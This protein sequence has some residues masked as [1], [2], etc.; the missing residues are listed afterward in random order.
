MYVKLT[1]TPLRD[2]GQ[3]VVLVV[4]ATALVRSFITWMLSLL[5]T[6][7]RPLAY[8][9]TTVGW[10]LLSIS[11]LWFV[12]NQQPTLLA[13][14]LSVF[15]RLSWWGQFCSVK[16]QLVSGTPDVQIAREGTY[17][18]STNDFL[19]DWWIPVAAQ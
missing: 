2:A 14:V 9:V 12:L 11:I 10:Q 18:R 15:W 16:P 19:C 7:K 3:W 4:L 17:P 5:V 1:I 8:M 13:Q 6:A